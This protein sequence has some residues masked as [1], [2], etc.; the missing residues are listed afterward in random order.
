ASRRRHATDA[1]W[2]PPSHM[3]RHQR[4]PVPTDPVNPAGTTA[5]AP[6]AA[7][8]TPADPW[9]PPDRLRHP[10]D[11]SGYAPPAAHAPPATEHASSGTYASPTLPFSQL[12][13]HLA[14]RLVCAYAFRPARGRPSALPGGV[15]P[16]A[17]HRM[18]RT[19]ANLSQTL[20]AC[21]AGALIPLFQLVLREG[22]QN[23][24]HQLYTSR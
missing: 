14:H 19:I 24:R 8:P 12:A 17:G 22:P 11:T 2:P 20:G 3:G 18:R 13:T 23:C 10:G 15:N 7:P 16:A 1:S 21:G 6:A 4:R 9:P 5:A